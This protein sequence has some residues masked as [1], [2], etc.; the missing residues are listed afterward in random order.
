MRGNAGD[1]GCFEIA[2]IEVRTDVDEQIIH[3]IE[4]EVVMS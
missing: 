3:Q 2:C 1:C 4:V